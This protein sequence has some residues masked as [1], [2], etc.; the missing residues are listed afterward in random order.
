MDVF[1]VRHAPS[2]PSGYLYGRTDVVA[3]TRDAEKIQVVAS[4]IGPVDHYMSSPAH[5]CRQTVAALW[6]GVRDV[7]VDKRL[8]EQNF[9]DW[10]GRA[11][12]EVPDLGGLD[13]AAL[14]AHRPPGGES[15]EDVIGRVGPVFRELTVTNGRQR[16]AIVAHAGVIR[17]ALALAL[18]VAASALSFEVDTLSITH[19]RLLPDRSVSIV[20][21]NWRPL[22]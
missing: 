6:P 15:F 4:M 1:L 20:R 17:A 9:G 7:D 14:A 19:I 13:A 5:R 10:D 16:V 8:W 11:F 21:T 18:D 12:G 2:L 3:D 22:C